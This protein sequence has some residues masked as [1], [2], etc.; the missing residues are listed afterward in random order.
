MIHSDDDDVINSRGLIGLKNR[1]F[2]LLMIT[3]KCEEAVFFIKSPL[4]HDEINS[5]IF[6]WPSLTRTIGHSKS[7]EDLYSDNLTQILGLFSISLQQFQ[8]ATSSPKLPVGG[9]SSLMPLNI[10]VRGVDGNPDDIL[11]SSCVNSLFLPS[12]TS[13]E[14][15]RKKLLLAIAE[16]RDSSQ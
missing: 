16:G 4:S 8:F 10:H 2:I 5:G 6:H 1:S 15:L 3:D 11:P 13:V 7:A 14:A 9:F 12:Y